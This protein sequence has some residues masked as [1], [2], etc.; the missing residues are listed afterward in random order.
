MSTGL[1]FDIKK[2]A[3]HDG[4]GIRTAVFFKGCPLRCAWC[5]NPES[6]SPRPE[7]IFRPGRCIHCWE[8]ITVCPERAIQR[9]GQTVRTDA[10]RCVQ[11]GACAVVCTAEARELV[12]KEM[13]VEQVVAEIERDVAFYDESGGGVTF[14]GGEPLMQPGFLGALLQA[15]KARS[16]HTTLDTCGYAPWATVE[17][18]RPYVDLFLYDLKLMDDARHRAATGMSNA[19]I[20]ANLR[21]L[22]AHDHA[23]TIRIPLIPGINDDEENLRQSGEFLASLPQLH[24]VELL[25]Y[26]DIAA[27]K[28]GG[29]G[30]ARPLTDT[31][32]PTL[33][34]VQQ[35]AAQLQRFRT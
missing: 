31:H 5:H 1:L 14:S 16:I 13:T 3:I 11:C 24:R 10:G 29:L 33:A 7:L 21:A 19:V 23:I 17:R 30:R 8:C 9:N 34:Q 4:P 12:G 25:P 22:S 20:L 28:Y 27:A 26:H 6:Q 32:P 18:I 35:A 2:Y 15:C